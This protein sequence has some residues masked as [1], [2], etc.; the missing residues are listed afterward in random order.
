VQLESICVPASV[1]VIGVNCF[2]ECENLSTVRFENGS[3]LARIEEFAFAD[4]PMLHAL[5]IPSRVVYI[6]KSALP[7]GETVAI[8]LENGNR[9][10]DILGH[11]I[12]D[13]DARSV[14]HSL[15]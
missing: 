12:V 9:A 8:S 11:L 4:C 15:Y 2:L 10:F 3:R 14:I 5:E 1:E 6:G 13:I 7:R